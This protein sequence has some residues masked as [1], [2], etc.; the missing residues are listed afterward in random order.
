MCFGWKLSVTNK[1]LVAENVNLRLT[2]GGLKPH[3][4]RN[5]D[6]D[7]LPLVVRVDQY[8]APS[9]TAT[10]SLTLVASDHCSACT[11]QFP[12]W[13]RLLEAG[14]PNLEVWL[15]S[16]DEGKSFSGLVEYLRSN[17]R[18]YQQFKVVDQATF[19]LSTGIV[20]TPTTLAIQD[21]RLL[22]YSAG[23]F[24]ETILS[25]MKGILKNPPTF[26]A[27]LPNGPR[28]TALTVSN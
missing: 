8:H 7:I 17:N 23:V 16:L 11:R 5:L 14:P 27:F 15:I 25:K 12:L 24:T 3:L 18:P 22:V 28:D 10:E 4:I 19:V 13:K 20:S 9:A 6:L 1:K 21:H 26:T 2:I